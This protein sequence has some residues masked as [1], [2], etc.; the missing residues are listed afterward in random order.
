[1][2]PL[3]HTAAARTRKR[4]AAEW[5]WKWIWK[6][7]I[8][9]KQKAWRRLT[10]RNVGTATSEGFGLGKYLGISHGSFQFPVALRDALLR[11]F[12]CCCCN[13]RL[14]LR[15]EMRSYLSISLTHSRGRWGFFKILI[16]F[17]FSPAKK[18]LRDLFCVSR[19]SVFR[20][21]FALTHNS[22]HL[23]NYPKL[24]WELYR[25]NF[26]SYWKEFAL[27]GHIWMATAVIWNR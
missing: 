14:M 26:M 23:V 1:M 22:T 10:Y 5:K 8:K 25:R 7:G 17:G 9:H 20:V 13:F 27:S 2:C 16:E 18:C 24:E 6:Y 11:L 12:C 19:I 3:S 15:V 4:W 21:C